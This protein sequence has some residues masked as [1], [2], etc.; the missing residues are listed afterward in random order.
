MSQENVFFQD[1]PPPYENPGFS[2]NQED[3]F[4]NTVTVAPEHGN[5]LGLRQNGDR[6]PVDS[7]NQGWHRR[8]PD[9]G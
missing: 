1:P 9:F 4:N 8:R 6:S 3:L 5:S 2:S 7:R